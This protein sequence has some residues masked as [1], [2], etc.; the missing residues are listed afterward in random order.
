MLLP[1]LVYCRAM[2]GSLPTPLRDSWIFPALPPLLVILGLS[3]I[4]SATGKSIEIVVDG[5][6]RLVRTHSRTVAGALRMAGVA[7]GSADRVHPAAEFSVAG[8]R[9]IDVQR[10][11]PVLVRAE[12]SVQLLMTSAEHPGNVLREAGFR[13]LPGDRLWADGIPVEGEGGIPRAPTRI[14][15]ERGR[16]AEIHVEGARRTLRTGEPTLAQALWNA[17]LRLHEGDEIEPGWQHSPPA[18]RRV[19]YQPSRPVGIKVDGRTIEVRSA[20]RTVEGLLRSTGIAL[21]G[22][23]QVEPSLQESLPLERPVEITRVREEVIVELAPV[24]FETNFQPLADAEIDTKR[25]LDTG[26]FGVEA[27]QIRVRF[28]DGEE[29]ERK[30]EGQWLAREPEPRVVGYG[31]NIIVRTTGTADGTI[32]YWR[33]VE[34]W[35]TSYS[36]SR[37]GV[38]PD[39]PNF[40]ITASGKP[41]EK[42][43]VAID[44]SLIPF[45]TRMYVPG[46][47][48]A[49]AADTGGGVKGR[50][51]DLGYED[52]NYKPWAQYVT[53]YFLTPVPPASNITWIL[54]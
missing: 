16:E 14:R 6:R 26:S 5:Q 21:Q 35:A 7:I 12:E 49:E 25:I 10:A 22:L 11:R 18:A 29:V 54:P 24:P 39:A 28:E 44:R 53:V 45:G 40:G 51:I 37:A 19:T 30:V 9:R 42:G 43:L 34:M 4:A 36:P 3:L 27:N 31:T 20:A 52:D 50:W 47:G 46:Y 17:G 32:E 1:A 41:L 33:A 13:L 15:L 23:D 48:F 38:S 2:F 8:L